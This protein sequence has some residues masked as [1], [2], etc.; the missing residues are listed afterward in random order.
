MSGPNQSIAQW[1]TNEVMYKKL[2]FYYTMEA[3]K[4]GYQKS[5]IGSVG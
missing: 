5:K 4:I 2:N 1:L 3:K